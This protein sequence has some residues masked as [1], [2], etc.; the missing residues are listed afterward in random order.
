MTLTLTEYKRLRASLPQGPLGAI[1]PE[2]LVVVLIV[3]EPPAEIPGALVT[4]A[5]LYARRWRS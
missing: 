2:P 4:A 5:A 3:A 1:W